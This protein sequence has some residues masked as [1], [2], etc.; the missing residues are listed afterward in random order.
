MIS[1]LILQAALL[2]GNSDD[3]DFFLRYKMEN[4]L[5]FLKKLFIRQI[6]KHYWHRK[7]N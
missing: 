5:E 6:H 7:L 2:D 1:Y 4:F 3:E